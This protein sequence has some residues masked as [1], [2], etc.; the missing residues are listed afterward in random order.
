MIKFTHNKTRELR[1]FPLRPVLRIRKI[2]FSSDNTEWA[3]QLAGAYLTIKI[4][5][6]GSNQKE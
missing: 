6:F 2:S 3:R 1:N 5:C 4:T